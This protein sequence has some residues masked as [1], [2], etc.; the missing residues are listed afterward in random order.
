MK[1]TQNG[2]VLLKQTLTI[3]LI[4]AISIA[5]R[6]ILD[7]KYILYII[8]VSWFLII[9]STNYFRKQEINKNFL[10]FEAIIL[11]IGLIAVIYLS[12]AYL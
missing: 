2:S 12:N 9:I 1:N 8:Y 5:L 4:C 10:I 11:V 7:S 3:V 6:F